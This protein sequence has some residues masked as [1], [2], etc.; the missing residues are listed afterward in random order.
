MYTFID[1]NT[2]YS[3]MMG[4]YLIFFALSD[5]TWTR[6]SVNQSIRRGGSVKWPARSPDLNPL[7]FCLWGRL[8]TLVCSAVFTSI[9]A[10]NR[11][12]LSEEIWVQPRIFRRVCTSLWQRAEN[13][14]EMHGNHIEHL[15]QTSHERFTYLS[16]HWF[17]DVCWL[18]TFVHLSECYTP[19]KIVSLFLTACMCVTFVSCLQ[20]K[21]DWQRSAKKN[22]Y[23]KE[24][25]TRKWR[26]I[27]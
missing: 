1:S 23:N 15:L 4:R 6:L 22:C 21:S 26:K 24:G 17:L 14:V 13:C 20:R 10:T 12:C 3:C 11:D 27:R 25:V 8:K 19:L 16:R 2:C 5:S 7:D 9:T 18:G